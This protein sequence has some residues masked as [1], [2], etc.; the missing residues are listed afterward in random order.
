[1][2]DVP[3]SD[4][5]K[6]GIGRVRM[7]SIAHGLDFETSD[8]SGL[9]P[10]KIPSLVILIPPPQVLLKLKSLVIL[11]AALFSGAEGSAVV[12]RSLRCNPHENGCPI[13]DT[14]SSWHEWEN[15]NSIV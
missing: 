6:S 1:M 12:L 9:R 14:V 10:T 4:K 13:Q 2:P 11:S 8:T 7:V 5:A 3:H 15:T